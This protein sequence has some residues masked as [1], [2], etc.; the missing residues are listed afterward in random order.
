MKLDARTVAELDLAGK[1]DVIFF[2]DTLIG[3][4]VRLR[5]ASGGR[6]R[7]SWIAQYRANG[8][9]RRVLL[10]SLE[11]VT[12]PDARTAAR[13]ILASVELGGDPQGAKVQVRREAARSVRSVVDAYLDA[14]QPELRPVSFR[15]TSLYLRGGSYFRSL[16]P[17]AVSSVTRTDVAAAVRAISRNHSTATASA[18]RRALSAFFGWAIAE[19]LLGDGANPVVGSHRPDSPAA[20][21]R[22]LSND[23]LVAIW[24]AC[25]DGDYGK[26]I[27][28]LILLGSRRQEVG[29]MRWSEL[30]PDAGTWE[31]PA[32][33]A[34]NHRAHTIALPSAAL[35]VIR[36]VQRGPRDALFGDRSKAGFTAWN[37][38]K[39]GLDRRLG[40]AV[41]A[42]WRVHDIRRTVAT[43]M[44]DIGIEPHHIEACLNHFGGHRSGVAGV[45][46]RS[47]YE[48]AV[49]AAL[50]RWS[51]HVNALVEN[52]AGKVVAL[53]T[54]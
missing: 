44:A 24:R 13:K 18:A 28:L 25:S 47:S 38:G 22:V 20:R 50:A 51:E 36:S 29:G 53:R 45:Y 31:L 35:D 42:P 7:R 49:A 4:G 5:R 15:I 8:R 40:D 10:G 34:K 12:A 39:E 2:D 14:K 6:V 26:I 32:A 3:F 52:R 30:N 23:E 16:H 43:G 9:T 54:S 21:D 41:K 1:N 17:L 48:R 19:G 11:K 46:N 27:Q 33:R 37:F